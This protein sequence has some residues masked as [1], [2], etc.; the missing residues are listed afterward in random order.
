LIRG[1]TAN[2]ERGR[3][4]GLFFLRDFPNRTNQ[5]LTKLPYDDR[6]ETNVLQRLSTLIKRLMPRQNDGE[7][8]RLQ[9]L[10]FRQ[11]VPL[12]YTIACINAFALSWTHFSSAPIALTVVVPA[13]LF[14][15]S[16]ARIAIWWRVRKDEISAEGARAILRS[17]NLFAVLLGTGFVAWALALS[18]YGNAYE[19]MH[20]ALFIG[21]TT[22][23]CS[24][25]LMH[26]RTAALLLLVIPLVPFS[27]R[28]AWSGNPVL[29]ATAVNLA[30]VGL[31]VS[32]VQTR[33]YRDFEALGRSRDELQ[34]LHDEVTQLAGSDSLTK[35][36]NRR[37]FFQELRAE[38]AN[39]L[40]SRDRLTI[41]LLDLDGFK[42]VNDIF[43]H[44]VGDDVLVEVAK[45]L[46]VAAADTICIARLG[47]DEFGLIVDG[48][49]SD[50]ELRALGLELCVAL[51]E[52]YS[53]G[54]IVAQIG[55][56][57]GIASFPEAA[58][59]VEQLYECADY[60]LYHSKNEVRGTATLFTAA[61]QGVIRQIGMIEQKLRGPDIASELDLA[62]QPIVDV[63]TG[64]PV[65]FEALAR[66]SNPELGIVP[67]DMFVTIAERSGLVGELT[68]TLLA[69][70]L[71]V[72][73][74]WPEELRLSFNLSAYD[75]SSKDTVSRILGI[76]HDSD[77]PPERLDLEVT[78]TALLKE[79]GAARRALQKLKAQGVKI[80]L[81]DFGSGYS[82]LGYLHQ[83]PI[84]KIKVD[85]AFIKKMDIDS[86]RLN[87]VRT[88]ID[89]SNSL[90][91]DC[92][93]EGI[94]EKRQ[95]DAV[96]R[97]G[98]HLMQGYLFAR[99]MKERA[100]PAYLE[101]ALQQGSFTVEADL[102]HL[103]DGTRFAV[104]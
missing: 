27:I 51:R 66:W 102:A 34:H 2:Q 100:I 45:R 38:L 19:H 40:I 21:L 92:V 4:G 78:E 76:I 3:F 12:M 59:E 6:W 47:G 84:D 80:V 37:C 8:L 62:F 91:L 55:C 99:P 73:S 26:L 13:I 71:D 52:P 23:A 46:R 56:S 7:L 104:R 64:Q 10:A 75:I 9:V 63:D 72:A 48:I 98:C 53:H 67:P 82:S 43:G 35:L 68:E 31:V 42:Q 103:R 44:R 36:S 1:D 14:S 86:P 94:E 22:F 87:I 89:M 60:A 41:V 54:D 24:L 58:N 49:K 85:R 96:R 30:L 17:T 39:A 88:I 28:F 79:F 25:C 32:I 97:L 83:L 29:I 50:A 81:D 18:G 57:V 61:H 15:F 5:L 65:S 101:C 11:Q 20:V 90:G 69:R 33:Y 93:V 70:S 74:A 16:V 77:F 95:L